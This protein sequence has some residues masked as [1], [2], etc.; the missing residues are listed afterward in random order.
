VRVSNEGVHIDDFYSLM[1]QS[2]TYIFVPGRTTWPRDRIDARLPAVPLLDKQG[3]P[4]FDKKGKPKTEAA[5]RYL[6]RVRP[7]EAMSWHPGEPLLI[8]DRLPASGGWVPR[9]G[10]STF[11]LYLPAPPITGDPSKADIWV[12][13]IR[14][15]YPEA[16]EHSL[17]WMA[18]RVSAPAKRSIT[19]WCGAARR[20]SARTP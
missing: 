1:T 7:V 19:R 14:M 8:K 16:A 6:D 18:H 5:S 12:E 11:N 15:I 4:V 2:G 3:R 9:K 20:A 10:V 13:H 17:D